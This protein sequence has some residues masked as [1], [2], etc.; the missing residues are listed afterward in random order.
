[1]EKKKRGGSKVF[2]K[3]YIYSGGGCFKFNIFKTMGFVKNLDCPIQLTKV[4]LNLTNLTWLGRFQLTLYMFFEGS[5]TLR[6]FCFQWRIVFCINTMTACCFINNR[7]QN[8]GCILKPI[9]VLLP[10]WWTCIAVLW[11]SW[12]VLHVHVTWH[13]FFFFIICSQ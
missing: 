3:I 12:A 11:A 8:N 13:E 2:H 1:M 9:F 7:C 5:I 6:N 10:H 4:C